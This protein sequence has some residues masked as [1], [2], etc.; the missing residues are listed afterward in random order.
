MG[1]MFS[2]GTR[3][4]IKLQGLKM[5]GII[6]LRCLDG[7][8]S[9]KDWETLHHS[10]S[11]MDHKF[12]VIGRSGG[13]VIHNFSTDW[14]FR[15]VFLFV[16]FFNHFLWWKQLQRT[17]NPSLSLSLSLEQF[18]IWNNNILRD[19]FMGQYAYLSTD[20]SKNQ[21]QEVGLM[22]RKSESNT[23]RPGKLMIVVT[24]SRDLVSI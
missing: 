22:G 23:N 15:A 12:M 19:E 18:Q 1:C 13:H 17:L 9:R 5:V 21:A 24:Q 14:L 3:L 11:W 4:T 6:T 10:F 2:F 8:C 20:E 7:A 16:S